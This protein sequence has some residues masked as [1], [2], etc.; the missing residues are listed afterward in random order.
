MMY[1]SILFPLCA[2]RWSIIAAQLPGRTDNDIKNYWNTRLKKKLLGKQRKAHQPRKAIGLKQ[3]MRKGIDHHSPPVDSNTNN[4]L[5]Y[6]PEIPVLATPI[7]PCSNQELQF[8]D[9]TSIRKL[10]MKLGG[11]FSDDDT[12][13]L[14]Y[15]VNDISST[16][17]S[18]V[19]PS[20]EIVSSA[21]NDAYQLENTTYNIDGEGMAVS[22]GYKPDYEEMVYENLP[23]RLD[24]LEFL[25]GNMVSHE[26][27][28]NSGKSFE[29]GEMSTMSYPP[30]ISNYEGL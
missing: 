4:Q 18:Y 19:V 17:Q 3:G 9:H 24:G 28:T 11:E 16:Q 12:P 8:N 29:W 20:I 30:I 22:S 23:Q 14:Q 21:S 27:E 7:V 15:P 25:F 1:N 13:N 10:L 5:P 26:A 6:W 2:N